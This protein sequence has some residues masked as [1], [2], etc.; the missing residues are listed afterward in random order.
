[1]RT[2]SIN[3][4]DTGEEDIVSK[5]MDEAEYSPSGGDDNE[6]DDDDKLKSC[7]DDNDKLDR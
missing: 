2:P 7:G 6:E 3:S 5:R 4:S 1:M